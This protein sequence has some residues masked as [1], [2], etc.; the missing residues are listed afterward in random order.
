M[1]EAHAPIRQIFGAAKFRPALN[2]A[3]VAKTIVVQTWSS[4]EE[5]ARFLALAEETDFVAGVVG[6]VDLTRADVADR[7]DS[8]LERPGGRWLVGIRHQVHDEPDEAWLLREDVQR[9]LCAVADRD[10]TY[11]LLIRPRELR[12]SYETVVRFPDMRFVVDH[13]AKPDIK[14]GGT[15]GWRDGL[16]RLAEHRDHVWIKLS[17]M[18]TEADWVAW[19]AD[20]IKPYIDTVIDLFGAD[21]CMLGS[22]W[23]VCLLAADYQSTIE[24]VRDAIASLTIKEQTSVLSGSA[25]SAYRLQARL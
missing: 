4:E 20:Q 7:L 25:T 9:G 21:R 3:D 15:A 5:T 17:G 13:I 12:A 10:L 23:P 8:L 16:A 18:V 24:L 2:S 22:D 14:G 1:T 19:R 11:D 6:W